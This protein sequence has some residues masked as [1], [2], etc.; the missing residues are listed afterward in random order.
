MLKY[1]SL[2]GGGGGGHLVNFGWGASLGS[3]KN[4]NMVQIILVIKHIS[5]RGRPI[6]V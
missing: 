6:F 4:T 1:F 3:R 5:L 2:G